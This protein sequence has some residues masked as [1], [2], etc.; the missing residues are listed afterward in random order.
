M[1]ALFR[2]VTLIRMAAA[3]FR[4]AAKAALNAV[5][6]RTLYETTENWAEDDRSLRDDVAALMSMAGQWDDWARRLEQRVRK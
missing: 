5:P 2:Q 1:F 4:R 3:A 6:D